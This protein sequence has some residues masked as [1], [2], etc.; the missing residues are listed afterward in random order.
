MRL[1]CL[2]ALTALLSAPGWASAQDFEALDTNRDGLLS[3][4][5]YAVLVEGGSGPAFAAHVFKHKDENGD[6]FLQAH[7]LA[8][9]R[10][11]PPMPLVRVAVML[12]FAEVD[13]DKDGKVTL[14]E[15]NAIG[16]ANAA[17][18]YATL[19]KDADKDGDGGMSKVEWD[20]AL[21]NFTV[22]PAR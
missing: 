19:S 22:Q 2:G 20:A 17:A 12:P 18:F 9:D 15:M 1:I 14:A 8:S 4:A 6:G 13:A 10:P 16:P 11:V 21:A 3:Q 5:E 7:E